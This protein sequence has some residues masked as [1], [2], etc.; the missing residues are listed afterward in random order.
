MKR[1]ASVLMV[2]GL[3]LGLTGWFGTPQ[4]AVAADMGRVIRP[5]SPVLGAMERRNAV[6]DKLKTKF[7]EK[8]DLNNANVRTFAR[9]PGMYPTIAGMI[10]RNSPFDSVDDVFNM[11]GLTEQQVSILN[12]HKDSFVVTPPETAIVEGGDRFNN[13][14]YEDVS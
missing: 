5:A 9:F 11:P 13:G 2:L 12:T 3:V 7:G 1:L 4:P 6:E 10:L 8:I 14:I